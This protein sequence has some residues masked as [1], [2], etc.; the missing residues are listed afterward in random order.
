MLGRRR[1]LAY[2]LPMAANRLQSEG[3][4]KSLATPEPA[5]LG[6]GPRAG[7][8]PESSLR[9]TVGEALRGA[10]VT[11]SGREL[12]LA[13]V[14]LWHDHL[15]EAHVIAQRVENPDGAFVH[16]ILH[17]REPDYGNATYWF[18][19]V[20]E[21]PVFATLAERVTGFAE[22]S[23]AEPL[24]RPLAKG[25]RWDPFAMVDAC[26]QA[27]TLA[28]SNPAQVFLRHV[29]RLETEV[30]LAHFLSQ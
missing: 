6:P 7:V 11:P 9:A 21:H 29:Q 20:G 16:G 12:M 15:E 19:R 13:L 23:D 30:L 2:V 5:E 24:A 18:R 4:L 17:R 1:R 10:R 25:K 27:A 8:L 3:L 22:E 14:L 26:A 28:T